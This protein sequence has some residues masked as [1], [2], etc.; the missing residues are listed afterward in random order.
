MEIDRARNDAER[1]HLRDRL[2]GTSSTLRPRICSPSKP[3]C[4]HGEE[5]A[6][7]DARITR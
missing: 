2:H 7:A 1:E 4:W 6:A 5:L 3:P